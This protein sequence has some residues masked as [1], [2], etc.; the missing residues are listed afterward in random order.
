MTKH[1]ELHT[2]L[3]RAASEMMSLPISNW[4]GWVI[5]LFEILED[6]AQYFGLDAD[7]DAMLAKVAAAIKIHRAHGSW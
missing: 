7:Y 5:Y 2:A 1:T 4:D 6:R 3:D